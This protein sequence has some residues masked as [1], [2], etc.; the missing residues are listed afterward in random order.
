MRDISCYLN[1]TSLYHCFKKP[2]RLTEQLDIKLVLG[3]T[4]FSE[5]WLRFPKYKPIISTFFYLAK[6]PES[7]L[8]VRKK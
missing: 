7:L 1:Y 4:N 8:E 3:A 6:P 2:K 5:Q